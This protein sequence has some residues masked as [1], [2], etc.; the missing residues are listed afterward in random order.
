[1]H[2][3]SLSKSLTKIEGVQEAIDEARKAMQKSGSK[4]RSST[5]KPKQRKATKGRG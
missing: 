1:M 5:R 3:S 2:L 4:P